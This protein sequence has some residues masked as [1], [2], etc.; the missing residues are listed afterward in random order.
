[1]SNI[2]NRHNVTKFVS[3]SSEALAG[4]RLTI[5]KYKNTDKSPAKYPSV[6]ASIP[7]LA[8]N[9]NDITDGLMIHINNWIQ[10][11]QDSV[12]KSVYESSGGNMASIGDDEI[13]LV[14]IEN[15]LNAS[16]VS[17]RLTKESIES[18]YKVA[19]EQIIIYNAA[20]KNGF[21]SADTPDNELKISEAQEAQLNK[22]SNA[23]RDLFSGLSGGATKYNAA[24]RASLT[25]MLGFVG[26]DDAMA[27][28]LTA[29]IKA[30]EAQTDMAD[31]L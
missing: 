14:A 10:N 13:S 6:C 21:I 9:Q 18:W 3:G 15:Y 30:M 5:A 31:L 29:R 8:I 22:V 12:F 7:A 19:M 25:K 11:V 2:S 28:R 24:V 26:E 23:Y 27:E 1:M 4:Q 20:V 17:G 16:A